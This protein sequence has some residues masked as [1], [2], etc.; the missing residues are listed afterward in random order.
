ME[1]K[2]KKLM[3]EIFVCRLEDITDY[4]E[5]KDLENWDSLQHLIFASR[6]EQE[7]NIKLTPDEI[8]SMKSYSIV[9]KMIKK[10]RNEL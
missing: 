2:L 3:A 5:K 4:T 9:L 6:I 7:F 1:L 10:L 8:N